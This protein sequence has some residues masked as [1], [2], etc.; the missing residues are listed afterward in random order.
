MN[1]QFILPKTKQSLTLNPPP[2]AKARIFKP[3][4]VPNGPFPLARGASQTS[5]VSPDRVF[6]SVV[7]VLRPRLEN[8]KL[9][10]S[11]PR[12]SPS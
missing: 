9:N 11:C 7:F 8:A 6:A 12:P 2:S 5:L 3:P 10:D 1:P 4:Q